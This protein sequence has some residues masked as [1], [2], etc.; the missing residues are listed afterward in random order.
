MVP[1]GAVPI[2][3]INSLLY[4]YYLVEYKRFVI[5]LLWFILL[6]TES[7][8]FDF[9]S[10]DWLSLKWDTNPLPI[11]LFYPLKCLYLLIRTLV[12]FPR[13]GPNGTESICDYFELRRFSTLWALEI[14]L[15]AFLS[16][17]SIFFGI[18]YPS[19]IDLLLII[20]YLVGE[21]TRVIYYAIGYLMGAS[22]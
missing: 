16:Y 6:T 2:G 21:I 17:S 4:R 3:L 13:D 8:W 1:A 15:Y 5:V 19:N 18:D 22:Y 20:D 9:E 12:D 10:D 7:R 11:R 14:F